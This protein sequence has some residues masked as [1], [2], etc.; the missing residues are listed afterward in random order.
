MPGYKHVFFDLDRTLWDYDKNARETVKMLLGKT[1][2]L[3]NIDPDSFYSV[4]DKYNE[5]VWVEYLGG[6]LTKEGLRILRWEKTLAEFSVADAHL[7]ESLSA[8]FIAVCPTMPHLIEGTGETLEYLF[9]KYHMHILTNGF[10][11]IQYRKMKNS[12]IEKYFSKVFTSDAIGYCKPD[13]RIFH[14]ALSSLNVRKEHA[15]MVGDELRTDIDGAMGFGI[16]QVFL[17]P[18]N[19]VMKKK[20]TYVIHK[21]ADLKTIL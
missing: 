4:Y 13:P 2:A 19:T 6:S 7:A 11:D 20:P 18:E 9:S 1:R 8:E 10:S 14:H 21:L 17:C 16:D 5:Q 15:L 12:G 3:Q